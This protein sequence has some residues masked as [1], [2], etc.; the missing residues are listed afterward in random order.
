MTSSNKDRYY[1]TVGKSRRSSPGDSQNSHGVFFQTGQGGRTV[2]PPLADS[3]PTSRFPVP[4][5]YSNPYTQPRSAPNKLGY[6]LNPQALYGTY[7]TTGASPQFPTGF[8]NY[9]MQH[10]RYS[11]QPSFPA[12]ASRSSTPNMVNPADSR[13]LPP[14]TT[15]STPPIERWQQPSFIPQPTGFPGN[16]IR[17]PAASYPPAYVAYSTANQA[18][19]YSYHMQPH[20]HVTSMNPQ[21]HGGMFEDVPRLDPRS[22]SPYS[23]GSGSSHVSPP[24]SYSPPPVSPTSPEEPTIK[25][26]R[27]RADAAQLKVLNETYNRTAFPSTEERIALAKMLDMSARSVQIWFQNKRQSMRQ[28]NRQSS[29]VAS[30]SHHPFSMSNQIDPMSE[31]LVPHPTSGYDGGSGPMGETMY[32]TGTSQDTSRSHGSHSHSQHHYH[33]HQ[34]SSHRHSRDQEESVD[35]RKWSRA[36]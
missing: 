34:S 9:E 21:G 18:N 6:D 7:Q 24:R 22:S 14:L 26:K 1:T 2:L 8:P 16:S 25:K 5:S 10:E 4:A 15:S 20:D 35:P 13:R 30:S 36:L 27:K 31:D 3:F 17:S 33:Q 19:A 11:P 12:Y 28:T 32:L 23:R 29:T